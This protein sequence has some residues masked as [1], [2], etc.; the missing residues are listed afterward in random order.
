[1]S[2]LRRVGRDPVVLAALA[3][4][5]VAVA[6]LV[7]YA[8]K[9]RAYVTGGNGVRPLSLVATIPPGERLCAGGVELPGGTAGIQMTLAPVAGPTDATVTVSAGGREIRRAE[10]DVPAFAPTTARFASLQE[11]ATADVCIRAGDADVAV[12]GAAALQSDDRPLRLSGA[13]VEARLSM[14]FVPE[15][16][17]R[18]SLVAQWADVMERAAVFRPGFV[19]ASLLWVVMLVLVP[20]ALVAAVTGVIVGA[21]GRRAAVLLA[22]VAFVS[23]G[24]WA[25][26]TLPFDSPDE[27]EHFA[28]LQSVVE[29]QTRPDAR[30]TERGA[31]STAQA[32]ALEALRH[33]TRVGGAD[34]RPPWTEQRFEAYRDRVAG[35]SLDN[36]GGYAETTRL[37]L[38]AYYSLLVPGY[39]A[40]G[41]DIYTQLTFARFISV[42]LAMI[43][44]F[45]AFGIVR[46]LLPGRP[47]LAL[48]AGLLIALH[49]MF[50]FIGG[51]VNNDVGVNAAAALVAYLGVRLL[52]R[53]APWVMAAFG[54]ALALTPVM[55]A[56][57]FA[58]FP[59][60]LLVLAGYVWRHPR[61]RPALGALAGVGAAFVAASVLARGLLGAFV[62]N[63]AVGTGEGEGAV[64]AG[65]LGTL[66][67]K[68]S[69]TWQVLFP[70]LPF[71]QEHFV[72]AWPFYDIYIVRG[73]GSFGWYSFNFPKAVFVGVLA[74]LAGLMVSGLVALWKARANVA[75]WVWEVAFLLT[76]PITVLTAVSFAYYSEQPNPVPGEQGRYLFTAAAPLA[77]LAAGALL[78]LP[79]GWQRPT[80]VVLVVGMAGLAFFGRLTYLVGVFT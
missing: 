68:L 12:A 78:G 50:S 46:E 45:C 69:Y 37:H 19:T 57:G 3:A 32:Y 62:E 42:L 20:V 55:K 17:A 11:P 63:G 77:A 61:W 10:I 13:P 18:R 27:S 5:L 49:P 33:P 52:R 41:D 48:T 65:I 31:Y 26:I 25:L 47:E 74:V 75:G 66:G 54:A 67:G 23:A 80:A 2:R 34:Q 6:L 16:G 28:Y 14:L 53:P 29:R 22:F 36:G 58:L 21:R 7:A 8:V 30:P 40:A 15:E 44:A 71:M 79:R 72:M 51:A 73:W 1:M 4:G 70:R 43:A 38:P 39:L 35:A 76:V 64:N 60:A 56:T 24:S 59:P 9:P